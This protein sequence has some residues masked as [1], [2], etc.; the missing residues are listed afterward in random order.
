VTI[1]LL[2]H[3][4]VAQAEQDA[5]AHPGFTSSPVI[6][7]CRTLDSASGE[8][9]NTPTELTDRALIK[10]CESGVIAF[11]DLPLEVEVISG[12]DPLPLEPPEQKEQ[13]GTSDAQPDQK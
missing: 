5:A 10:Q 9:T 6:V 12:A 11:I 3:P 2:L 8:V 13:T 7:K 1:L 4:A